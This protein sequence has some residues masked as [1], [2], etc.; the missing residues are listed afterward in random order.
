MPPDARSGARRG[1]AAP[2]PRAGAGAH[3][4]GGRSRARARRRAERDGPALSVET[5]P[6]RHL[7]ERAVDG[8]QRITTVELFFDLVFVFAVTQLSHLIIDDLSVAGM[9][10]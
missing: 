6:S 10:R 2:R 3:H 1:S 4:L 7:R 5:A 8:A 9:A